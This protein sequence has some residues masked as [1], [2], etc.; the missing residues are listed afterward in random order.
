MAHLLENRYDDHKYYQ[1][2]Q[3]YVDRKNKAPRGIHIQL[4]AKR[5]GEKFRKRHAYVLKSKENKMVSTV[6]NIARYNITKGDSLYVENVNGE[7][8]Q[9]S[10][11]DKGF[12]AKVNL[13]K[14]SCSYRKY[15]GQN[16]VHSCNDRFRIK[17]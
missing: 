9:L 14:K 10:M 16:F 17:V 15:V 4:I 6:K 2:A 1:V 13:L 12:T 8:N 3:Y 11:F 5:F 7:D